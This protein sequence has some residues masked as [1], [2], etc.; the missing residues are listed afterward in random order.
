MPATMW[1]KNVRAVISQEHWE[2]LR[3]GFGATTKKP[4]FLK[5]KFPDRHRTEFVECAI[6]G[7]PAQE[8]ELHERWQYDDESL[9]QRLEGFDPVCY[10][11]HLALH[12][13]RATR[14]GLDARAREHLAHVNQWTAPEVHA[15]ICE[16]LKK[17]R[18]RSK[19]AYTLDF[20]WLHQ[21]LAT[22]KIHLDWLAHPKRRV[23]VFPK[24]CQHGNEAYF[25]GI[26][27]NFDDFGMVA[28]A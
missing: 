4:R 13:G 6:C 3:W 1:G 11:C 16:A 20:T 12:Y 8:L 24:T 23:V 15:Q 28:P 19:H 27:G 14:V 5:I 26:K 10:D 25:G 9:I 21:S 7:V 17:W 2:A 22:T 18:A